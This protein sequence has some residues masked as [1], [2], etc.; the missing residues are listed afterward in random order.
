MLRP[1]VNDEKK[2]FY[3]KLGFNSSLDG[4][5]IFD[6]LVEEIRFLLD[7]ENLSLKEVSEI[8]PSIE[9]EYYH[10]YYEMG[11][12]QYLGLLEEFVNSRFVGRKR[13]KRSK[14]EYTK[15]FDTNDPLSIDKSIYKLATKLN[16]QNNL[17]NTNVKALVK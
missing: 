15:M 5:G 3:E 2:Q 7:T 17:Q 13:L 1:E 8:L 4:C 12:Y 10:F 14:N 6:D 16:R 9:L 11:R